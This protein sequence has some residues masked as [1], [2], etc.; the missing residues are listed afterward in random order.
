[1]REEKEEDMYTEEGITSALE[2][3]SIT[4]VE[5]GFMLGYLDA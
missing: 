3:G 2:D 1:M 4:D 5:T